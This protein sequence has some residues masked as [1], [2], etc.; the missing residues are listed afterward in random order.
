MTICFIKTVSSFLALVS[1]AQENNFERYLQEER[2][3]VKYCFAFNHINYT[4]YLSYQQVYLRELQG[5]N[6]NAMINLMQCGFGDSLSGD[7]F[8]WLHG[9]ITKML[10]EQRKRQAGSHC[11][12]FSTDIAKVNSWVAT[13]HIH[14]KVRQTFS[15]KNIIKHKLGS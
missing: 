12:R 10:N 5:I 13:S 7:L 4:R 1:A 14:E 9:V 11:A 6:N 3:M 15:E 8:S 2:E